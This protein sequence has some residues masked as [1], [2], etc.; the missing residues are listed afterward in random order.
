MKS[1]IALYCSII[2]T[3][4][5]LLQGC[6]TDGLSRSHYWLSGMDL[7]SDGYTRYDYDRDSSGGSRGYRSSRPIVAENGY[8]L[9]DGQSPTSHQDRDRNWVTE[10]RSSHYTIELARGEK[11]A[12]V[13][14][15]LQKTPKNHRTAEVKRRVN[16]KTFY[17]G[18]YGTY[19]SK[20][21]ANAA[22]AN[23]PESVRG[24]A[25]VKDWNS[26][27]KNVIEEK[28]KYSRPQIS[29]EPEAATTGE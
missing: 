4:G 21:E 17:S 3:F 28:P 11:A 29:A 15:V 7:S 18:V 1:K 19:K 22:L 25:K 20:E 16:D 23:L 9:R 5:F 26:M 12:D 2:A 14:S 13:A 6:G 8:Y 24:T 27:Q 10:Q